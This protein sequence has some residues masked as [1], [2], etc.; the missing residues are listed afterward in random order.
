MKQYER[1]LQQWKDLATRYFEAET[2]PAEEQE[3]AYFLTTPASQDREFDEIR[4]VMGYLATG[5]IYHRKRKSSVFRYAAAAAAAV[6]GLL[7]TTTV[8]QLAQNRNVCVAYIY[9]ERCTDTETV[10]TEALKS[11]EKV[12]Q[13]PQEETILQE[14]LSDIFQT[15]EEND[16][17]TITDTP[18]L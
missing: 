12:R 2:T 8:W 14:Q 3:L 17:L 13:E 6:I 10:L 16:T 15:L 4:A 1:T 11:I 5:R 18:H 7:L 9:G